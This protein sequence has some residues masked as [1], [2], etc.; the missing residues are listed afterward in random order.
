[1]ALCEEMKTEPQHKLW[2]LR[3]IEVPVCGCCGGARH[4]MGGLRCKT[5]WDDLE[6]RNLLKFDSYKQKLVTVPSTKITP[7]KIERAQ[8]GPCVPVVSYW[9]PSYPD[10]FVLRSLQL[11]EQREQKRIERI[12]ICKAQL[13]ERKIARR[14]LLS[15]PYIAVKRD[16]HAD[17]LAVNALVPAWMPGREDVCQEIMLALWEKQITLEQLKANR[18]DLRSFV[19]SFTKANYEAG[20]FAISLDQPM[21]DGRS[22]HDVL[23]D[24]HTTEEL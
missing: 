6:V 9:K 5:C 13:L 8:R 10:P 22:W 12:A 17:L 15:Y 4:P 7:L 1:M 21:Y 11:K 19:R 23:A 18:V 16:E 14:P 2:T 3:S 24:P 20:G